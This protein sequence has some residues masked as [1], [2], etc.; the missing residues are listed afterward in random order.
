MFCTD[1]FS[2]FQPLFVFLNLIIFFFFF[3]KDE[4]IKKKISSLQKKL[5]VVIL[6][7]TI[8]ISNQLSEFIEAFLNDFLFPILSVVFRFRKNIVFNIGTTQINFTNIIK[9]T[10]HFMCVFILMVIIFNYIAFD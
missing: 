9:E 6:G 10:I 4:R 8:I 1:I 5:N 2:N 3:V 7:F